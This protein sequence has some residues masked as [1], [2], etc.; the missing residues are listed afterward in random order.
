[1]PR[2]SK[3]Q[4]N[5]DCSTIGVAKNFAKIRKDASVKK[6]I[7]TGSVIGDFVL[8]RTPIIGKAVK[9]INMPHQFGAHTAHGINA[10]KES[11]GKKK[12]K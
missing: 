12:K 7:S 1:M 5:N 8:T 4:Y 6:P 2:K 9:I 10:Y 3:Y 11:C